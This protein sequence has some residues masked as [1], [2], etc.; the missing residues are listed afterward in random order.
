MTLSL[1]RAI[2]YTIN[3]RIARV[4]VEK[5]EWDRDNLE[6]PG[7][8]RRLILRWIFRKWDGGMDWI[9]LTQDRD[10]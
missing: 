9:D 5:P 10:R 7:V 2:P 6:D 4:L 1:Y 3:S 8:D